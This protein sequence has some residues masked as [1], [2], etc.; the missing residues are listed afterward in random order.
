MSNKVEYIII[1]HTVTPHYLSAEQ[2]ATSIDPIH[3]Q[4]GFSKS[5]LGL[6]VGYH[7]IID[8]D[9]KV[10]QC[11]ADS[12]EGCHTREQGMNFKSLGISLIGN[13][14]NDKL[15]GKQLQALMDLIAQKV[16]QYKVPR[17]KVSYHSKFKAT[18]CPG[19]DTTRQFESIL[20]KTFGRPDGLTEW[21]AN[22]LDWAAKTGRITDREY[23]IEVI[24][25]MQKSPLKFAAWF[26]EI[27]RKDDK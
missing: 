14:E 4:R 9:G 11:R 2:T 27:L 21:E 26:A 13:F 5:S 8:K 25:N 17:E 15:I 20:D 1:H 6:Y 22:A 23:A 10:K 3:K 7:Y 16:T 19:K 24:Q 18:F 12:D